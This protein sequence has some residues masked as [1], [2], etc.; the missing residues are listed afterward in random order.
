MNDS[1]DEFVELVKAIPYLLVPWR[2]RTT[3]FAASMCPLDGW[4]I[5][6][7]RMFVIVAM[8]GRVDVDSHVSDPMIDCILALSLF[9][10]CWSYTIGF[11]LSTGS[12]LQYGVLGVLTEWPSSLH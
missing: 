8:S 9:W 6:F 1:I 4:L 12:P 2:Y 3:R 7:A 11:I 5:Y 10:V